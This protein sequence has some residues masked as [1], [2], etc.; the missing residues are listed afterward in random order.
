MMA[1]TFAITAAGSQVTVNPDGKGEMTFTVT[2]STDRS[3]RGLLRV[4]P[5]DNAKSQWLSISGD[6]ERQFLPQSTQQVL[7]KIELPPGTPQGSYAFRLDAISVDNPDDDYS[8]GPTVGLKIGLPKPTRPFPWKIL[9]AACVALIV[10]SLGVWLLLPRKID[11]PDV[12]NQ[13]LRDAK[14]KIPAGLLVQTK[15]VPALVME[16]TVMQQEPRAGKVDK[17]ATVLLTVATPVPPFPMPDF[18][19]AAEKFTEAKKFLEDRLV[20]INTET[21]QT[22]VS[23]QGMIVA[24]APGPKTQ[25]KPGDSVTLTVAV[26]QVPFDVPDERRV[27]R[28]AA[29]ADL[30]AKGLVVH[31]SEVEDPSKDHEVVF[32]QSPLPPGK[33]RAGQVVDINVAF[34]MVPVPPQVLGLMWTAARNMIRNSNLA[35]SE[36]K[37]DCNAGVVNT[38]PPVNTRARKFSAV[39]LITP[40]DPNKTCFREQRFA[41]VRDSVISDALRS[42]ISK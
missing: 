5:L 42:I 35:L 6:A 37:G 7:V 29:K 4:R 20:V 15:A 11:L 9:V 38:N 12:T 32:D 14:G 19:T 28:D 40:G 10:I 17:G 31:V 41:T 34:T 1:R 13:L 18:V 22:D 24:Q 33:V 21:R 8:E 26:P 27:A 2:N 39:T 23:P 16:E 25:L 36:V 3:P 30:E